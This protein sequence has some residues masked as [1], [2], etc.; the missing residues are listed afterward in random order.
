MDLNEFADRYVAVW[1]E[2]D[3]EK[4]RGRVA[5]LWIPEGEHYVESR[6]VVGYGGP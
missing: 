3:P 1:N 6:K 5:E 4:R 2:Q